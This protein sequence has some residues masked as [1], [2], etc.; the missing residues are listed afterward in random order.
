[1]LKSRRLRIVVELA[2]AYETCSFKGT[3]LDLG[4]VYCVVPVSYHPNI[5]H[6]KEYLEAIT[7]VRG[8]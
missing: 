4:T 1:M 5:T 7:Q 6:P 2:S 8:K 3:R